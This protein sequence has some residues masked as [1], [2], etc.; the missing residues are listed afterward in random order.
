MPA[1]NTLSLYPVTEIQRIYARN[2][3]AGIIQT[4]NRYG[5][6]HKYE[7]NVRT[8]DTTIAITVGRN[9]LIQL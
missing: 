4:T 3:I 7:S 1:R 6:P 2:K 9:K 8:R 5:L